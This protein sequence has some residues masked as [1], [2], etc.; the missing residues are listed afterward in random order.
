M[1]FS[2]TNSQYRQTYILSLGPWGTSAS[3]S[4]YRIKIVTKVSSGNIT[5]RNG[6]TPFRSRDLEL[7][8]CHHSSGAEVRS[9]LDALFNSYLFLI[10]VIVLGG[11]INIKHTHTERNIHARISAH[12]HAQTDWLTYLLTLTKI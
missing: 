3:A 7:P 5:S 6:S 4:P 10:R 11:C 2:F 12:I 1:S 9:L 8:H